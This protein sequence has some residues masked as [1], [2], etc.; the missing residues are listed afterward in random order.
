M[1]SARVFKLQTTRKESHQV[2][3]VSAD[4]WDAMINEGMLGDKVL[5][6][7]QIYRYWLLELVQSI[8]LWLT[9]QTVATF[10]RKRY[11]DGTAAASMQKYF[12]CRPQEIY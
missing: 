7:R 6:S 10:D 3:T 1:C 11:D 9:Q 12:L 5:S 4:V 2:F 8:Q